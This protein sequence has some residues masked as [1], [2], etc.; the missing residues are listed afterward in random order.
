ML[1]C[2][3]ALKHSQVGDF[4]RAP[5]IFSWLMLW[6]THSLT[7][8]GKEQRE[9]SAKYFLL[10]STIHEFILVYN[11]LRV[12][13]AIKTFDKDVVF[14]LIST[15]SS[16]NPNG[17]SIH[18]HLWSVPQRCVSCGSGVWIPSITGWVRYLVFSQCWIH[19]LP[20]PQVT[21]YF[22]RTALPHI[23]LCSV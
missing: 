4:S 23:T 15:V 17:P 7:L 6:W 13:Y 3:S 10:S 16:Q 8:F 22:L 14:T 1:H 5:G 20:P 9:H 2:R 21:L 18:S 11:E 19:S 12:N